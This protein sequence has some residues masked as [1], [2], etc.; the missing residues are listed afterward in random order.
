MGSVGSYSRTGQRSGLSE[1]NRAGRERKQPCGRGVAVVTGAARGMG[2]AICRRLAQEG[3]VV[4]AADVSAAVEESY[5]RAVVHET[6]PNEGFAACVDTS[7]PAS[8]EA[9]LTRVVKA[10]ERLDVL[11]CAAGVMQTFAR[12]ADLTD[13]QWDKVLAVNLRGCFVDCRAVARIMMKQQDGAIIIIGSSFSDKAWPYQA[14]SHVSKS[15][16]I[17]LVKSLAVEL[18]PHGI[19]VNCVAPGLTETDMLQNW[20]VQ[21]ARV[22][23][24][25]YDSWR[26]EARAK[27]P[28]NRFCTTEEVAGVVAFVASP[29]ASYITGSVIY[30]DGGYGLKG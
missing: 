24:V 5:A 30:V 16:I 23:N 13:E 17:A 27:I 25:S 6:G 15:G 8:F 28:L 19:R 18:A 26:N 4:V 7:D 12:V 21:N 29:A 11:V 9:L 20:L 3:F 14:A 1:L 10:F 22:H 2:L